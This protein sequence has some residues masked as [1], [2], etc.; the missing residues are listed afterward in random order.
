MSKKKK[1]TGWVRARIEGMRLW[2]KTLVSTPGNY[3]TSQRGLGPGE[4][5]TPPSSQE[6]IRRTQANQKKDHDKNQSKITAP[7]EKETPVKT[8]LGQ[9]K[10][11]KKKIKLQS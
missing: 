5:E 8:L 10:T 7:K 2:E 6:R 3:C 4:I 11:E 1:K 9:K